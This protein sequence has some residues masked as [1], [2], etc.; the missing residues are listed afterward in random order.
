MFTGVVEKIWVEEG[1]EVKKGETLATIIA[2][3][4]EYQI[5]SNKD[6]IVDKILHKSGDNVAK[7]A[8]LLTFAK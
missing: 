5:K 8:T 2:M 7:G 4:M 6:Q 3:K 1:Q